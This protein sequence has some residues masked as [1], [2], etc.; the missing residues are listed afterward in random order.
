MW[1]V[2]YICCHEVFCLWLGDAQHCRRSFWSNS[3]DLEKPK[4]NILACF[5]A[6][7]C[8]TLKKNLLSNRTPACFWVNQIKFSDLKLI[9]DVRKWYLEPKKT[10]TNLLKLHDAAADWGFWFNATELCVNMSSVWRRFRALTRSSCAL[11][12]AVHV[13]ERRDTISMFQYLYIMF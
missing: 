7:F 5:S 10:E 3:D 13:S 2:S 4:F 9:F 1:C 11:C 12:G 6:C 8:R